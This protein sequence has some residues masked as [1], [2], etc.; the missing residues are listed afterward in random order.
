MESTY[1]N[2]KIFVNNNKRI[3]KSKEKRKKNTEET[4]D[5]TFWLKN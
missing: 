5:T 4:F 3:N 2:R 1:M